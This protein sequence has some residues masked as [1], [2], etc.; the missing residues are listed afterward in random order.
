MEKV[1]LLAPTLVTLS[2]LNKDT[3][4]QLFLQQESDA[5]S[6]VTAKNNH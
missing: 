5:V 3:L 6:F 2:Y 1:T 4:H